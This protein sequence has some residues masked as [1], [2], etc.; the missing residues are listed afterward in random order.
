MSDDLDIEQFRKDLDDRKA[1]LEMMAG[2]DRSEI[3]A[4]K[5]EIGQ[6]EQIVELLQQQAAEKGGD[7]EDGD[8]SEAADRRVTDSDENETVMDPNEPVEEAA[9]SDDTEA[10]GGVRV[11]D[12]DLGPDHPPPA[13]ESSAVEHKGGLSWKMIIVLILAASIGVIVG[14]V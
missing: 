14:L 7:A 9:R 13:E 1:L 8:P 10:A 12:L 5:E 6:L 4:M 3:L 2:A 11:R